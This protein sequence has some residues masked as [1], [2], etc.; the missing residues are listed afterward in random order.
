MAL[1]GT[2]SSSAAETVGKSS[3]LQRLLALDRKRVMEGGA[4]LGRALI[5]NAT[6][7]AA[8][9][10]R[11]EAKEMSSFM[12]EHEQLAFNLVERR[13][14]MLQVAKKLRTEKGVWGED[15]AA[16]VDSSE[17]IEM[18]Q[19][20]SELRSVI[21]QL[22][23]AEAAEQRKV[24]AQ[25]LWANRT[26]HAGAREGIQ[27]SISNEDWNQRLNVAEKA[28]TPI[29]L[30]LGLATGGLGA[31]AATV[32]R[33]AVD[34]L[35][36][37]NQ[38]LAERHAQHAREKAEQI[39]VNANTVFVQGLQGWAKAVRSG[40]I[41]AMTKGL[42]YA[43]GTAFMTDSVAFDGAGRQALL[44]AG[45]ETASATWSGV[46]DFVAPSAAAQESL[47]GSETTPA[48]VVSAADLTAILGTASEAEAESTAAGEAVPEAEVQTPRQQLTELF[49]QEINPRD[50]DG[51]TRE[52]QPLFGEADLQVF[53]EGGA[54]SINFLA[55]ENVS[56]QTITSLIPDLQI[57]LHADAKVNMTVSEN[58]DGFAFMIERADGVTLDPSSGLLTK[59]TPEG[60]A[61]SDYSIAS[62]S[63]KSDGSVENMLIYT[64]ETSA[65][66]VRLDQLT[67][68]ATAENSAPEA[69]AGTVDAADLAA[70]LGEGTTVPAGGA[71][72]NVAGS[73]ADIE[74]TG[75]ESLI[76]KTE[77][78]D[79]LSGGVS[80]E[81]AKEL[82]A[83]FG[84][85]AENVTVSE[86]GLVM[87]DNR[88][89]GAGEYEYT[90]DRTL[91]MTRLAELMGS[92]AS[93]TLKNAQGVDFVDFK[94]VNGEL[95]PQSVTG[96]VS[97]V[98][99]VEGLTF[100]Y[101]TFTGEGQ[102]DNGT[103]ADGSGFQNLGSLDVRLDG[104]SGGLN[105]YKTE[106]G[107]VIE[108][109][110]IS[111]TSGTL[112]GQ[113]VGML[114]IG[115]RNILA[116]AA[117]KEFDTTKFSDPLL[118]SGAFNFSGMYLH[119]PGLYDLVG[120][121]SEQLERILSLSA[122]FSSV[123]PDEIGSV[124]L[125]SAADGYEVH[126]LD[127]SGYGLGSAKDPV[128]LE[129]L[130][131]SS[132]VATSP[133][134]ENTNLLEATAVD[135]LEGISVSPGMEQRAMELI[136]SPYAG[137]TQITGSPEAHSIVY[138]EN[139]PISAL[140]QFGI[141][142]GE[143]GQIG[144]SLDRVSSVYGVGLRINPDLIPD[145]VDANL[146][147]A[148]ETNI[149]GV[150]FV[151]DGSLTKVTAIIDGNR[152]ENI[153][154]EGPAVQRVVGLE[155]QS[156]VTTD[157]APA[158]TARPVSPD[159]AAAPAAVER[160]TSVGPEGEVIEP[161]EITVGKNSEAFNFTMPKNCNITE[162]VDQILKKLAETD[163]PAWGE[164]SREI[165]VAAIES[166]RSNPE[167]LGTN[168]IDIVQEGETYD[169][170]PI[171]NKISEL[172]YAAEN[173]ASSPVSTEVTPVINPTEIAPVARSGD[174]VTKLFQRYLESNMPGV[175]E[176][177]RDAAIAA[178]GANTEAMQAMNANVTNINVIPQEAINL[179]P[180]VE[181][182][183]NQPVATTEST[184]ETAGADAAGPDRA[185][186]EVSIAEITERVR[187][188]Y[189]ENLSQFIPNLF[190]TGRE[191][192]S[193]LSD[194]VTDAASIERLFK[195]LTERDMA[196]AS[197]MSVE[198]GLTTKALADIEITG[199][200]A[201][202]IELNDTQISKLPEAVRT[203][204]QAMLA[205]VKADTDNGFIKTDGSM[206]LGMYLENKSVQ[207]Q[208][209][210]GYDTNN[211]KM[212]FNK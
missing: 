7:V 3:W 27:K 19:T 181:A 186:V 175:T 46:V 35:K 111:V 205:D 164:T 116:F 102:I 61:L 73:G 141:E 156:A 33:A 119:G 145:N 89:G 179:T 20:L 17:R 127:G 209:V 170:S 51:I 65:Q 182:L 172:S 133:K 81:A 100:A 39:K 42:G 15:E 38:V 165:R 160:V 60:K 113:T 22:P 64:D 125:S 188:G 171:M 80:P 174:D 11:G 169:L 98:S 166:F 106:D 24:L 136:D 131:G 167:A 4:K 14:K 18:L 92:T 36:R 137:F 157:K 115:Q 168:N 150:T 48:G 31:G 44:D 124:Y 83:Q 199:L 109:L 126:L 147:A 117:E 41:Q 121:R 184:Y 25:I 54:D 6:G 84:I 132:S 190:D 32:A 173:A 183:E 153:L 94:L 5:E 37:V 206:N 123:V 90:T 187:D 178:V 9:K 180:L 28:T 34:T 57:D 53:A 63:V 189:N 104:M 87:L 101:L 148:P 152:Y 23:K 176:V 96:Q 208:L 151:P 75:A 139:R 40:D 43:I 144:G 197:L 149:T 79:R 93:D 195:A 76:S 52:L 99:G 140:R 30:A 45:K 29:I 159:A 120:L 196:L 134:L 21:D 107:L 200:S 10:A 108:G 59:L 78:L 95:Q 1:E 146:L 129:K 143:V 204:L 142:G 12:Q 185:A 77:L 67:D 198:S 135:P 47:A 193:R 114:R 50:L 85:E 66:Q 26:R 191:L 161:L 118:S 86:N 72:E 110:P 163:D 192:V 91:D 103:A 194:D 55:A 112:E 69:A 16:R 210:L 8:W 202:G 162:A 97:K 128:S 68:P 138:S 203:N 82:F 122:N 56:A 58:P 130:T 49:A 154:T 2:M 74:V 177:Q 158:P 207:G 71:V 62:I 70:I 211:Q 13:A 201:Q 105:L 155:G 212:T 88:N